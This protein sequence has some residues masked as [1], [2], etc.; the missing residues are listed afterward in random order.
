MIGF[1]CVISSEDEYR[2]YALP[3][4]ER[5][6]EPGDAIVTPRGQSC[7]FRAY[8]E[9]LARLGGNPELEATVLVHQDVEIADPGFRDK[10]RAACVEPGV[11]VVGVIGGIG[12]HS[13]AWWES[14]LAIGQVQW[15]WLLGDAQ[16][17]ALYKEE[18]FRL[19]TVGRSG[20]VDSVD[21]L[22]LILSPAATRTLR[23]DE[24]LGPG[25][26]GYDADICFQARAAGMK[27]KVAD[28][29]VIHHHEI[30][31]MTEP[32]DWVEAQVRFARKWGTGPPRALSVDQAD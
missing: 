26:H 4:I 23:F 1:G 32:E 27:V 30:R 2:T 10:V 29:D 22:I 11:G 12:V 6:L 20:D 5:S 18:E 31:A 8:N 3:G 7:I 25:F 19:E 15:E 21:G 28:I 24:S 14:D 13:I 16:R 17:R 9:I